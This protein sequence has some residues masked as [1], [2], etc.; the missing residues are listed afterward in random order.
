MASKVEIFNM[1]LTLLKQR[2]ISDPNG[3]GGAETTLRQIY[4]ICRRA[5][6]E[7]HPWNFAV[8]RK[9]LDLETDAPESE[10]D[11]AFSKPTNCLRIITV[12]NPASVWKE[13]DNNL[14]VTNDD[15]MDLIYVEDVTNP[16]FFSPLFVKTLCLELA[17]L[18]EFAISGQQQLQQSLMTQRDKTKAVAK[19]V[20]G[21]KDA[22]T[23]KYGS[24]IITSSNRPYGDI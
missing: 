15:T 4:D 7:E 14:I 10:Y 1:A 23:K 17:L 18:A 13:E 24:N 20:D 3:D 11:Y 12:Y 22:M 5:L 6:L 8:K 9:A 21:Q 19:M 2:P 16:T